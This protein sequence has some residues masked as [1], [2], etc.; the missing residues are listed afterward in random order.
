M[1]MAYEATFPTALTPKK[2]SNALTRWGGSNCR[3]AITQ[4]SPSLEITVLASHRRKSSSAPATSSP[5]GRYASQIIILCGEN[6]CSRRSPPSRLQMASH[7]VAVRDAFNECFDRAGS[8]FSRNCLNGFNVA[9]SW[10]RRCQPS[11][12]S[13]VACEDRFRRLADPCNP[14]I[15]FSN[16]GRNRSRFFHSATIQRKLAEAS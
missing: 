8:G 14:K 9:E 1:N 11:G 7:H 4:P 2:P 12:D 10:C 15:F 16:F 6:S 3:C 13:F 5:T